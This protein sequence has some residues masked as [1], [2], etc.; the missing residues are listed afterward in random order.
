MSTIDVLSQSYEF[1]RKRTLALLDSIVAD[2]HVDGLSWRPGPGRAHMAW[3]F[4]HIAITE[5]IFATERLAPDRPVK[6]GDAWPRFRGGSI[7][8]ETIPTVDE[9][10]YVLAASRASLIETLE[11][12]DESRL[13][14]IPPSL[15][16]RGW[17]VLTALNVL[18]WHE[19]HHQGQAHITYNLF[20]NHV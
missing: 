18:S 15:Q 5:E 20:K 17:T 4:M 1:N 10:R 2:G 6:F 11:G 7:P 8:D 16:Q 13:S 3:Q 19:S 12:Y 14:E 9:I